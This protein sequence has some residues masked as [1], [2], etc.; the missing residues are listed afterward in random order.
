MDVDNYFRIRAHLTR[1]VLSDGSEDKL[2]AADWRFYLAGLLCIAGAAAA[3][4]WTS[5][6]QTDAG[7][8]ART[9]LFLGFVLFAGVWLLTVA[10]AAHVSLARVAVRSR[11]AVR[12]RTLAQLLKIDGGLAHKALQQRP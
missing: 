12:E 4:L 5:I 3:V 9:T 11:D 2:L 6:T 7:F 8:F 10:Q 1:Q